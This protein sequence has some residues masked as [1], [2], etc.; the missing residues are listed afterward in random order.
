M[1]R[2][3]FG[4]RAI[5]L[6]LAFAMLAPAPGR[7]DPPTATDARSIFRD[8]NTDGV[9]SSGAY[10]PQ[11][12]LIR[13]FLAGI[14]DAVNALWTSERVWS[15]ID[16]GAACDGSTDDATAFANAAAA[17]ATGGVVKIPQHKICYVST[18]SIPAGVGLEG[19]LERPDSLSTNTATSLNTLPG[20]RLGSGTITLAQ[21]AW[22][23]N[24]YIGKSGLTFPQTSTASYSGT[25]LTV[26]ARSVTI[27]RVLAVGFA[28]CLA[29]S[30]SDISRYNFDLWCDGS[31]DGIHITTPNYDSSHLSAHIWPFGTQPNTTSAALIRAGSGLKITGA[32][33][34]LRIGNVLALGYAKN[35][36]FSAT[37]AITAGK[38]WS[39]Y[40]PAYSSGSG[41]IGLYLGANTTN[42][43]I[44]SLDIWGGETGIKSE[45]NNTETLQVGML[46]IVSTTGTAVDTTGGDF[47]LPNV[48][49]QS[50]GGFGFKSANVGTH[51]Y[52]RG[53]AV[54]MTGALV[55]APSGG[56]SSFLDIRLMG[57]PANATA[58]G[59]SLFAT[60][61]IAP[62]TLASAAT[63]NL[64]VTGDDFTI[65][66]AT[67]PIATLNGGWGNRRVTLSF[68]ST[69][70]LNETGNLKLAGATYTATAGDK[71][72]FVYDSALSKFVEVWRGPNPAR[73]SRANAPTQSSCGT[74]P[75]ID[76]NSNRFS[77][78]FTTGSAG[79]SCVLTWA[80]AWNV[81]PFCNVTPAA[82]PAAIANVPY[83]SAASTSAITVAGLTASS[84]FYYNCGGS[85]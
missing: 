58:D 8:Y 31:P 71:I 21:G 63:I 25:A 66:G 41:S 35:F 45:M 34:D 36:D 32:Q 11:K 52:A 3:A 29:T 44:G 4:A 70:T 28:K 69:P 40:P 72:A 75:S 14:A 20:L 68:L 78:K 26:S 81:A 5:A 62:Q 61:A 55:S 73:L 80:T 13:N 65:S 82:A 24:L 64:P 6:A 10:A 47:I 76:A 16:Y 7:A 54:G 57:D 17:A 43:R 38:M 51:I 12:S 15:P 1:K 77:G 37:G 18:L 22:I 74:S 48:K 46:G 79:T 84:S 53:Y 9:P 83:V 42:L 59:Q 23:K 60:N 85:Q 39:D 56:I 33:D 2:F 27:S 50:I 30:G 67:G 49:L 19:W